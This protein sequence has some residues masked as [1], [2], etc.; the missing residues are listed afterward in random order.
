ME[1]INFLLNENNVVFSSALFILAFLLSLELILFFIGAST[2]MALDQDFII[3]NFS[4]LNKGGLPFIIV[5]VLLLATFGSLG[6]IIQNFIDIN[7]YFLS[8]FVF[9]AT[10]FIVR[11][12]SS[13]L[14]K[15][16]PKDETSIISEN[17]F[18]GKIG[19]VTIGVGNKEN[20]VEFKVIDNLNRTHYI[21]GYVID[22]ELKQGEKGLIVGLNKK[23]KYEVSVSI[24][25]EIG[26]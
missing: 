15:I 1:F 17:S 26:N 24:D 11:F 18:I 12:L 3:D 23:G 20:S 2:N 5:L 10:L 4:W 25:N 7:Q 13:I 21:M 14:S 9:I 19:I 16:L 6:L 22:G 8:I